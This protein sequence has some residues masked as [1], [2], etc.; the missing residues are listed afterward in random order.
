M[1]EPPQPLKREAVAAERTVFR[2]ARQA[3]SD[4][5]GFAESFASD[6]EKD[7]RPLRR[8]KAYPELMDGMSVFGSLEAARARWESIREAAEKRGQEVRVGYFIAEVVLAPGEGFEIEDLGEPDEHLTVWGDATKLATAV[9][10]I[11]SA[12]SNLD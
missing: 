7:A 5:Q 10:R 6:R 9:R 11:Y 8:E 2:F 12:E 3:S 1:I 4:D